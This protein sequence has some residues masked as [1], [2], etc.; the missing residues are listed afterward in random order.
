MTNY[1]VLYC[2]NKDLCGWSERIDPLPHDE[3]VT[4]CPECDS[5]ALVY[6]ADQT[7]NIENFNS[8]NTNKILLS[9]G[10]IKPL[11]KNK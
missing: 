1:M 6:D 2:I 7:H 4:S 8:E 5:L 9:L 10:L 11:T 3:R